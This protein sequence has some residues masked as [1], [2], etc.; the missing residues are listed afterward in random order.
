MTPILTPG[1]IGMNQPVS[2]LTER[3]RQTI[4]RARELADIKGTD[5]I[6]NYADEDDP[7]FAVTAAFGTA[8]ELLWQLARIA[9]RR[10]D[11]ARSDQR[12]SS[13]EEPTWLELHQGP[14]P[15]SVA[16]LEEDADA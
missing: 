16:R 6:R 7:Y 4:A 10:D 1:V 14:G 3:D 11:H 2:D 8:Q 9:E 12:D 13:D 15:L 5:A